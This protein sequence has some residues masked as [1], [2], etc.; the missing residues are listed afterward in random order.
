MGHDYSCYLFL[1]G[2]RILI[3]YSW[4][5]S[6][7]LDLN[8]FDKLKKWK[9]I[10]V[11]ATTMKMEENFIIKILAQFQ[12]LNILIQVLIAQIAET[13]PM[14]NY[15]LSFCLFLWLD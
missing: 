8:S 11:A 6:N 13:T 14:V 15:S 4:H 7:S 3:R 9:G 2:G 1:L 5:D 12:V 10:A